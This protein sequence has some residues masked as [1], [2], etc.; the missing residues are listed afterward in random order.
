MVQ[1]VDRALTIIKIVSSRKEGIQG[2]GTSKQT[3]IK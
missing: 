1:S 2:N 3:R